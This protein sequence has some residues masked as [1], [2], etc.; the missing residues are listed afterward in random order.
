MERRAVK[1]LLPIL[2]F[3]ISLFG[4]DFET[5]LGK[6]SPAWIYISK[7]E[8]VS[9]IERLGALF[10]K[11]RDFQ[12]VE[13]GEEKIPKVIHFIWLGPEEISAENLASWEEKHPDWQI[14]LW[15]DRFMELSSNRVQIKDANKFPFL[16]SRHC[17]EESSSYEEKEELLRFEILYREGGLAVDLRSRCLKAF[18]PL[19]KGYDFYCALKTPHPPVSG[20]NISSM[21][22][23]IGA[24]P[25]H[26]VVGEFVRKN[27][28][29]FIDALLERLEEDGN[30]DIVFPA[31]YFSSEG[32]FATLGEVTMPRHAARVFGKSTESFH[33]LSKGVL[34]INLALLAGAYLFV[35]RK[36]RRKE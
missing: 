11:N 10:E 24:A 35:R 15:T 27:P 21:K 34:S 32:G 9:A 14:K 1:I 13:N 5:L 7:Q 26:P 8:D 17:Y 36:K 6:D 19:H 16:F 3:S 2:L 31:S 28:P 22:T 23:I 18:D 33:W 20:R 12:C 30:R 4:S 25:F 29:Y